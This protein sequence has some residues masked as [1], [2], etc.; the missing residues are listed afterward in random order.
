MEDDQASSHIVLSRVEVIKCF[1]RW[2][3]SWKG[4]GECLCDELIRISF[5]GGWVQ[6]VNG[7]GGMIIRC[8]LAGDEL[9]VCSA[10]KSTHLRRGL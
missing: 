4:R 8:C 10:A 2:M 7:S 1:E 9:R 5:G 6:S 3:Q